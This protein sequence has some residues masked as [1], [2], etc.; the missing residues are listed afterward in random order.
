VISIF[1]PTSGRPAMFRDML[2]SL[3][4]T[5]FGYNVEV[6]AV[7]DADEEA[8]RYA[9]DYCV[10][11]IDY[12]PVRRGALWGWNKGLELSS[13]EWLIPAGDDQIF[14]KGWLGYAI[15]AFN[16]ELGGYGVLGMND[17]AYNGNIQVATM[18]MFDRAYC[19]EH[20]G[21]IFAPPCYAYYCI[22]L[23]WWEKAR[24]L[25]RYYWCEESVVE[26]LHSAHGKRPVDATDGLKEDKWMEEDN[27][28]FQ[29]RK[30]EGFPVTWE[31]LI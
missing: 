31:P 13:G 8:L 21:G 2:K 16:N 22:D 3:R 1:V 9:Y 30:L 29:H 10:D 5:T 4:E 23:E 14:H 12:S 28:M 11:T 20:M 25:N 15:D 26:H 27:R 6:V 24:M 7:I 19:Q 18:W 17:L